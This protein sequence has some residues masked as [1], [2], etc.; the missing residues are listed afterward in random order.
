MA[1][2]PSHQSD[3]IAERYGAARGRSRGLVAVLAVALVALTAGV[4]WFGLRSADQPVRAALHS[5]DVPHGA[6]LPATI[7]IDREPGTALICDLVAVD[8]RM[9]VVGQLEL[10]VPAGPEEHFLVDA[11]I[12]LEGDGIAPRLRGCRSVG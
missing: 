3:P 8:D 11:D 5:W 1:D 9:I 7:E 2:N 6:V 12:P 10:D 4:V